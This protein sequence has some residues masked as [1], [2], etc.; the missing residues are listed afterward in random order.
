MKTCIFCRKYCFFQRM[1]RY[2][3]RFE[4]GR[5]SQLSL[6]TRIRINW[7]LKFSLFKNHNPRKADQ[8]LYKIYKGKRKKSGES[9]RYCSHDWFH[10]FRFIVHMAG[11]ILSGLLFTWLVSSFQV[12]CLFQIFWFRINNKSEGM[13][14]VV[15]AGFSLLACV[16]FP[17]PNHQG[18]RAKILLSHSYNGWKHGSEGP[19]WHSIL[20][21]HKDSMALF[22]SSIITM[23]NIES[24]IENRAN[25]NSEDTIK[26]NRNFYSLV[27]CAIDYYGRQVIG[28]WSHIEDGSIFDN[29]DL[30]E[31]NFRELLK[32]MAEM[33]CV[34]SVRIRCFLVCIFSYFSVLQENTDQK[35][36][37]YGHI[38]RSDIQQFGHTFKSM[39]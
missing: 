18:S 5:Y 39:F 17:M 6:Y 20:Q 26:W 22:K 31:G 30:K 32:L 38:L 25:A 7:P 13:K 16:L 19:N 24:R 3:F 2:R 28:L 36:S 9:K 29:D 8:M 11:F 12:Y 33:H 10:P 37:E 1:F 27:I 21:C 4:G 15:Y 14:P 23:K 35:N 34:K